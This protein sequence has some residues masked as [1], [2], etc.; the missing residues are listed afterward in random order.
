MVLGNGKSPAALDT[1][2]V[3]GSWHFSELALK[4]CIGEPRFSYFMCEESDGKIHY[5]PEQR[6]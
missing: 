3:D 1:D 6:A 2:L 4:I 5:P